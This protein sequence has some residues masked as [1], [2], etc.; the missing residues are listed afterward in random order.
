MNAPTPTIKRFVYQQARDVVIEL[1]R[2]ENLKPGDRLPSERELAK[3]LGLNHQTIRRSLAELVTENVIDRQVG[4]GT[5][6]RTVPAA[7]GTGV[8]GVQRSGE[9]VAGRSRV[10]DESVIGVLVVSK[11]GSFMPE[12][13]NHLQAEARR[14]RLELD[15]RVVDGLDDS[16]MQQAMAMS[17]RG[18]GS[19]IIATLPDRPVIADVSK[20]ISAVPMPVTLATSLAGL[21]ACCYETPD[22]YGTADYLAIEMVCDYLRGLGYGKIA[23]FGPDSRHALLLKDRVFAYTQYMSLQGFGTYVGLAGVEATDVDRIVK[24]WVG[25]AGDLAV[26]CYDDDVA[27]RLMTSCHK[28]NLRIPEDIA[29]IGFNNSVMGVSADPPLSTVQF[30]YAYVAGAMLDHALSRVRGQLVQSHGGARE[31]LV[32][33]E[34]C[35]GR[36]RAGANLQAVIDAAQSCWNRSEDASNAAK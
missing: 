17:D 18:C 26:I 22:V 14:R 16:A 13:L 11:Q 8:A 35:G 7:V 25:L 20:L 6:L 12:M 28:Q 29:I 3:R 36:R 15:V 1:I 4:A 2:R 31:T 34:S 32:V 19:L 30:D 5:F 27:I 9:G 21:E 33:R 24:N 23:F 10:R